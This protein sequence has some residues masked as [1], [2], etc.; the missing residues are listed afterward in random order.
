VRQE[1]E[2]LI[3]D[4]KIVARYQPIADLRSRRVLACEALVRG[5]SGHTL[6][7]PLALFAAA[8]SAGC[9][10]MLEIACLDI[11]LGKAAA[12][13]AADRLF[14]NLSPAALLSDVDWPT[15]LA[16]LCRSHRIDPS[17]CVLELTERSLVDDY[18]QIRSTLND[19]RHLGFDFA[20][21][22]LGTGYSGLR[23]WSEL[24]PDFVKID[25]YF[26]S[27]IDT[28]PVKLEFVRSIVA[29]GRAIGSHVIAEGVETPG[30]CREL[31]ELDVD[32]AQG[33]F[34]ARPTSTHIAP[35]AQIIAPLLA[36]VRVE[37]APTAEQLV[38]QFTPIA[39][40]LLI[41]DFVKLLHEQSHCDAF[42]VV[43]AEGIPLG[44]IWRNTFLL[45]YS[46]PLQ[47]ELLNKRPVRE[48]MDAEPLIIDANLRLGQVSQLVTRRSRPASDGTIHH[49]P[50]RALRR[51]RPDDRLTRAHHRGKSTRGDALQSADPSARQCS[52]HGQSEPALES[53]QTLCRLLH[54]FG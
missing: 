31:L 33:F 52:H 54:R 23:M 17:V 10:A 50:R 36:L 20:I 53:G 3:R 9:L 29:M 18:A 46:R 25:R 44:M 15:E 38:V 5:P 42:P 19:V 1:I 22:D 49:R 43:D 27:G 13:G 47:P 2:Q 41:R 14:L 26:I 51:P 45:R 8:E 12:A 39:P 21:D 37:I 40:E 7:D 24:R 32:A 30:E 6:H 11:V 28:D 16:R 34:F 4:R 48:V 35:E